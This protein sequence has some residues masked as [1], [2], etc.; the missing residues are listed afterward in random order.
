M[1]RTSIVLAVVA[2]A[3]LAFIVFFERGTVSQGER[4]LRKGSVIDGFVR[5]RTERVELQRKGV[6][7]VLVRKADVVTGLE[8]GSWHVEAPF[9]AKADQEAVDSVL[10]ALEW[11][12]PRRRLSDLSAEDIRQFGFDKPRYRMQLLVGRER[13][14]FSIGVD[15]PDGAGV[16]LRVDGVDKAYVVT[17]DLLEALNHEPAHFHTKELYDSFSIYAVKRA[18]LRDGGV[19][20]VFEKRGED[21]WLTKPETALASEQG[22]GDLVG[23]IDALRATRYLASADAAQ[24]KSA[25]ATP[26][27]DAT[28]DLRTYDVDAGNKVVDKTLG[29]Q[30]GGACPGHAD[31]S[32]VRAEGG[33]LM[34]AA[35]AD[36]AKF[37]KA[38]AAL[39]EARLLILEDSQIHGAT[40]TVGK[41]QLVLTEK[42]DAWHYRVTESGREVSRGEADDAAVS[43]WWK[44]LRTATAE[45]FTP[46]G[47]APL[48]DGGIGTVTRSLRIERAKGKPTYEVRLGRY[49][50]G[51]VAASR[52][53]TEPWVLWFP[54]RAADLVS[55]SVTRFRPLRL[56]RHEGSAFGSLQ[57]VRAGQA[58]LGVTRKDRAYLFVPEQGHGVDRAMVDEIV[59]LFSSLEAVRFV[60]DA[61][62]PEHGLDAPV[63]TLEM[64]YGSA[65]HTLR[66]G[67]AT[68]G[69][70]YA[71]LD[72]DTVVFVSPDA[73][74]APLLE[75]PTP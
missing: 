73:L 70:R 20:T 3:L 6:T 45:R 12:N 58:P 9:S 25:L 59:R 64:Q 22:L 60:A 53:A 23:A 21:F 65:K 5:E 16:Y 28:L 72:G 29:F 69:G 39:R 63:L 48:S 62:L 74:T 66:V 33:P 24:T 55:T 50:Q 18:V 2:A 19:E 37:R 1:V 35:N 4:D 44:Q 10:S 56:L 46:A 71:Q 51:L 42:D 41:R 27:F 47:A 34:C 26:V 7:T 57:L 13:I 36:I 43:D 31:E 17:K 52:L 40:V 75:A 38:P 32:T 15:S 61:P 49:D 14:G 30:V 67:A 8:L 11:I 68:D 54:E